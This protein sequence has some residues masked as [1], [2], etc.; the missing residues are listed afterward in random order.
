MSAGNAP[1]DGL[2]GSTDVPNPAAQLDVL[3][4]EVRRHI[5]DRQHPVSGLLPASTAVTAHGD[6]TDA[7]VRD[8]VYS[9]LGA[10]SLGMAYR[11]TGH[12][13]ARAYELEQA[14]VRN[15]RGLLTAMM[16]QSDR[17]ERFKH[18]LAPIDA[19]HAKY[20]TATGEAVVGDEEWGHLQLDA[21][22]LFVLMLVQ[23][24]LSGLR[25]IQS[26]DE[27]DFVQ[28]LVWYLSRAYVTPD[29]GIWERGNKIN[30]GVR[31]LNASSLG[32]VLAALE[33]VD[34][35][36]LFG[37][38][39]DASTRVRVVTDDIVRVEQSLL[40]LLPRESGSKEVDSALFA[41]IGFPG[42]AVHDADLVERID[43][44]IDKRLSG[45]YGYKRF[46]RDGH[47][48]VVEDENK[49]HYEPQ[50]LEAF[51]NIESEWPLFLA[52]RLI[53]TMFAGDIGAATE[54]DRQLESLA[55]E[56]NGQGLLPEL[57]YVTAENLEEERTHPGTTQRVPNDNRPLV[58]A[59]SLWV[60][61]RLLR[62]GLVDVSDIDPLNR[63]RNLRVQRSPAISV[64]VVAETDA[65]AAHLSDAG[66]EPVSVLGESWVQITSARALTESLAHVGE[67]P[68]LGL[69]GRPRRRV[70]G[71][72]TASIVEKDG[73]AWAVVPQLFETGDF[74][75]TRDLHL[76]VHEVRTTI[77]YLHR[78]ARQ[79]GRPLFL[80]LVS[81]WMLEVQG[82]DALLRFCRD[83]L[84]SGLVG[85][86][87]VHF[88][89]LD[90]L[91]STAPR[92]RLPG[93]MPGWARRPVVDA[94]Q[95][96]ADGETG[97]M[98]ERLGDAPSREALQE[99]FGETHRL[100]EQLAVLQRL[101]WVAA[102]DR[103]RFPDALGHL[104]TTTEH[105]STLFRVAQ[106]M[107]A[108]RVMRLAAEQ[109]G[110]VDAF[111]EVALMDLIVRHKRVAVGRSY[112]SEAVIDE[113]VS[114]SEILRR[115]AAFCGDDP[116]ERILTQ[117]LI[118]HLGAWIRAEP[119]LF[120]DVITLRI[121]PL[122]QI[123]VALHAR[124]RHISPARALDELVA[125][126][127]SV[128]RR[129]LRE[130]LDWRD[131][132]ER[133]EALHLREGVSGPVSLAAGESGEVL[134][135]EM[136]GALAADEAKT[137]WCH[138]RQIQGAVGRLPAGFYRQLWSLL[139]HAPAIVIGN[140]YDPRNALDSALYRSQTT[141]GEHNFALEVE[142]LLN[143]VAAPEYRQ[144][145]IE[146]LAA[147][148]E[149][150]QRHPGISVEEPLVLDVLIGH[151]V[152][153]AW[154][155]RHPEDDDRYDEVRDRAWQAFYRSSP[156]EVA[157]W[158]SRS[159]NMLL[160]VD[161]EEK[162]EEES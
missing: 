22:S 18:S 45:R 25:I 74:Y 35:F 94:S 28:N 6:Y 127:P 110:K 83:E 112:T 138:Y 71:L 108:W 60:V 1:R 120:E 43:A 87:P 53:N 81:E 88:D 162:S 79:A 96:Q 75:L 132:P 58:W 56:E 42:F 125:M 29:Y 38:E 36:D 157:Q 143:R 99:A 62:H 15:M 95:W 33:A 31:E 80:F 121:G 124:E 123:L 86:V 151:A 158:V 64:A 146:A 63:R 93:P 135:G 119:A 141:A 148:V 30:R 70:L 139:G 152:R 32:L 47:Q 130:A 122:L 10:W 161:V 133:L 92:I 50:E 153:L 142:H 155:D 39:G 115:I 116:R 147:L 13:S 46:L 55:I 154:V 65:V 59:Q 69:S 8:N 114:N 20:D 7:W 101:E 24:T 106:Q 90:N 156:D 109:A 67:N 68:R 26:R 160:G 14:T 17:V 159:L 77:D 21:T 73:K 128:I 140:R 150:A 82:F 19:L 12:S 113:P 118:I 49:L 37:G 91:S 27:V 149:I 34:G 85:E 131:H 72:A 51:A 107:Q 103:H 16:R 84:S 52:F 105:L 57:Y 44:T 129:K 136:R 48:T 145:C 100:E 4:A 97:E 41:V 134:T 104:R 11:R 111:L 9:V 40:A 54:I 102:S 126:A 98:L 66:V 144:L 5:L 23:M 117:E 89:D 137:D 78:N 3:Y 61:G 76:L 2:A